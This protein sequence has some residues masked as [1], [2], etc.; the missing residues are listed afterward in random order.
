MSGRKF[1]LSHFCRPRASAYEPPENS[2]IDESLAKKAFGRTDRLII[3]ACKS[4]PKLNGKFLIAF[5]EEASCCD[6]FDEFML[7][8]RICEDDIK[9]GSFSRVEF[10]NDEKEI[11][12]YPQQRDIVMVQKMLAL[13]ENTFRDE[14]HRRAKTKQTIRNK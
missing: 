10:Q 8:K 14:F 1:S 2:I 13:L 3:E 5:A 9:I 12:Y 11:I 4:D 7:Y 6:D